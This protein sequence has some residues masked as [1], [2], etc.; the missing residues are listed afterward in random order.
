MNKTL[1]AVWLCGVALAQTKS[2]SATSGSGAPKKTAVLKRNLLDPSTMTAKAPLTFK[3]RF[4]TTKGA[5][6]IQVTRA[7]SPMG[8]DRFYNLVRAGFFTDAYFFRVVSG[9][10]AQFGVPSRPEVA[11]VWV[12]ETI[13][14]DPVVKSNTR[15]MVTFAKSSAPNRRL[16][17][18][19]IS[20]GDNSRLDAQN[21]SPFGEV[22][23]G[24]EVVD[25]LYSGYGEE[26]NDQGSIRSQGKAFLESNFPKLDKIISAAIVPVTPAAP[27]APKAPASPK[28]PVSSS[29]PPSATKK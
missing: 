25:Q 22:V 23:Q 7:W 19:F 29:P 15:G 18:I 24:M 14:D 27:A 21:F 4:T 11:Q 16:T 9:F 8:A 28:P 3:A 2:G 5:F 10:M 12:R 20:Y 6:I 13:P 17:Q 26:S 1:M